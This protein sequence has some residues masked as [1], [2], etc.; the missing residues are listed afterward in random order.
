MTRGRVVA[1]QAAFVVAAGWLS[2]ALLVSP[3]SAAT[4]LVSARNPLIPRPVGGNG[5][6]VSPYLTPD[7]N[8]VLYISTANDLTPGGN[9][10]LNSDLY[11][12]NRASNSNT[13]VSASLTGIG[14]GNSNSYG[15]TI[16]T[17]GR[18]V[19]FAS[20]ASDLV[21]GDTNNVTDVFLRDMQAG[22]TTLISVATNGGPGNGSSTAPFMTPDG[23][24]V[25]FVSTASNLVANDTNG[26]PGV[27][28]RD[29]QAGTTTL[30][31]AGAGGQ[32]LPGLL[33]MGSPVMTPNGRYV[34]FFS[35]ASNLPASGYG[36]TNG[37]IY[38]C[39]LTTTNLTWVS[40]NAV[41]I[42]GFAGGAS[43]HPEI[44]DD[45]RYVA[46]KY[47]STNGPNVT[48][49]NQGASYIFQYDAQAV[50]MTVINSNAFPQVPYSDDV[51]GPEMTP[52]GRYVAFV[53]Q[54]VVSNVPY[55]SVHLWDRLGAPDTLVSQPRIV[56]LP[57]YTMSD[58][59]VITPDGSKVAFMSSAI[60]LVTNVVVNGWHVYL[61]DLVGTTTRLVDVDTNGVGSADVLG[62]VPS[63]S[64]NGQYVGFSSPDG[65]LVSG[66]FNRARDVFLRDTVNGT[67]QMLSVRNALVNEPSGDGISTFYY[68][69]MTATGRYL[70]YASRA[71]DLVTNDFNGNQDVFEADLWTGS[72]ALVSV[73]LDGNSALG[74]DSYDP[75][76][77]GDG[78]YVMFLSAAT[79]LVATNLPN[80]TNYFYNLYRRDLQTGTTLLVN[81]DSN[82]VVLNQADCLN[83]SMSQDGR[84]V[85][86]SQAIAN[87]FTNLVVLRDITAEKTTV[88]NSALFYQTAIVPTVRD[89]GRY[90]GYVD[91]YDASGYVWD[92]MHSSNVYSLYPAATLAPL[93]IS[94]TGT[95][96]IIFGALPVAD[97]VDFV[98]KSNLFTAP[99]NQSRAPFVLN[100]LADWSTDARFFVFQNLIDLSSPASLDTNNAKDIFLIDLQSSNLTVLS[101][102]TLHAGTANGA[103]DWPSLSGDGRFVV[104][105][106]YATDVAT[107]I[108]RTPNVILYDRFFN[109]NTLVTVESPATDWNS[110]MAKP[111]VSG[112]G[113]TVT[114]QSTRA[115]LA[116]A[117]P[118]LNHEINVFAAT[119]P[120]WGTVDTVGDGIPDEWRAYYFGG[121]GTTTNSQSCAT[122][123]ADGSG[124]S[125]LQDYL[126]GL[127]PTNAA[128]VLAVNL[129]S[130]A[131]GTSALLKWTAVPGINYA[132][133]Y[134]DS[135][136][137]PNWVTATGDI[138]IVGFQASFSAPANPAARF[139][140]VVVVN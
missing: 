92:T 29:T 6:S 4:Q 78:R 76:V 31:S 56:G 38:L 94:P 109:T 70:V 42:A 62:T 49:S 93:Y 8:Y 65:S 89:D 43:T 14:G 33:V 137:S 23:R 108:A 123:D 50:T 19:V 40:S 126:A 75:M 20:D 18:Y 116:P 47:G 71:D 114:F 105:R 32:T 135:L 3:V 84:Y 88:L 132:V 117:T 77:S 64:T 103:S 115:N 5:D 130:V 36:N 80:A 48:N 102:S 127:N 51:Y 87:G 22:T 124:M 82:G 119:I 96:Y 83:P 79:N 120:I 16:S 24:Y 11:V 69:S 107:G 68:P 104:Y 138:V 140:R 113:G 129:S 60:T 52:D 21:A 7:G 53:E 44:S 28:V 2:F 9:N 112:N 95:R 30:V 25:A 15:G 17:N 57:A 26:I 111:S 66:D 1:K 34:A 63:L 131:S 37:E 121:N 59:P 55:S 86:Y 136:S 41:I 72:N 128:S 91:Y 98:S 67:N 134:S 133:Q 81:V 85:A 35:T 139:Y 46:F 100:L 106:S 10:R 118:V 90:V 74:G 54:T 101:T 13:L 45:G 39:D 58:T 125:N 122:C 27:F 99:G 73:G 61:R 110:M 12:W 97:A